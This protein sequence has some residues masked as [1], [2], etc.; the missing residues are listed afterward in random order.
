MNLDDED[1]PVREAAFDRI[2]YDRVE[3]DIRACLRRSGCIL[4]QA[5][6]DALVFTTMEEGLSVRRRLAYMVHAFADYVSEHD[7]V[8][9]KKLERLEAAM[10]LHTVG[11]NGTPVM[12]DDDED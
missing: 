8:A 2:T 4:P 6:V 7:F 5:C 1:D 12:P 3:K 9:V 10:L 11:P